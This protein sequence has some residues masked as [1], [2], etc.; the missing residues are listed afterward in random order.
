MLTS[1]TAVQLLYL[2]ALMLTSTTAVQLLTSTTAVQLL[3]LITGSIV[4]II[5]RPVISRLG[6]CRQRGIAGPFKARLLHI[7]L[8]AGQHV[9]LLLGSVRLRSVPKDRL[10][11]L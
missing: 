2:S 5:P 7:A 11:F 6:V 9:V 3:E 1:T 10:L 8:K 4:V